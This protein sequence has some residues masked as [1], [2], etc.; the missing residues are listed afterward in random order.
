MLNYE[1][2]IERFSIK[3]ELKSFSQAFYLKIYYLTVQ[4][5]MIKHPFKPQGRSG[6]HGDKVCEFDMGK[7]L[8]SIQAYVTENKLI[9]FYDMTVKKQK[10]KS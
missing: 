6:P 1:L 10:H 7:H 4:Q 5:Y 2:L 9:S 3:C 8:F